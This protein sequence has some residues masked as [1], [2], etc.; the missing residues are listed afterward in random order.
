M[1]FTG[2]QRQGKG[3]SFGAAFGGIRSSPIIL[4]VYLF[5]KEL[6]L[7][8]VLGRQVSQRWERENRIGLLP[9]TSRHQA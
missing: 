2:W 5:F 6:Q 8:H 7:R 3:K 1:S 4:P 9:Y